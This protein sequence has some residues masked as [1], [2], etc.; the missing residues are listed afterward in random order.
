[1][2]MESVLGSLLADGEV[3]AG[4]VAAGIVATDADERTGWRG[5]LYLSGQQFAKPGQVYTFRA[6]DGRCGEIVV[7]AP[8]LTRT[9]ATR[10]EFT[11]AGQWK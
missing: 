9:G 4:P 7:S 8:V 10:V 11:G 6:N 2:N 1:M 5:S 3:V